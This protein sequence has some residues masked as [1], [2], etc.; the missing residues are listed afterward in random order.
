MIKVCKKRSSKCIS[1]IKIYQNHLRLSFSMVS[2]GFYS[3]LI[4]ICKIEIRY[5]NLISREFL[6][7]KSRRSIYCSKKYRFSNSNNHNS[8]GNFFKT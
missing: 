1:D 6:R 3:D 4:D 7:V 5:M 8:T 2:I